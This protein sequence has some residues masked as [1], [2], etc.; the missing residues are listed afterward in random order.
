MLAAL[1][2]DA[3]ALRSAFAESV[4]DVEFLSQLKGQHDVYIT[5]DHR[6]SSR[7]AEARAIREAGV[8]AIWLGPFWGKKG[9]WDQAKWLVTR[10]KQIENFAG[11]VVPG[12]C[13][14][15]QENGRSRVFQI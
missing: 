13:A 11:S 12:T 3:V 9:R 7:E 15:I 1:E 2:V 6:Q 5:Y 14:V 8:T 4:S 10:W